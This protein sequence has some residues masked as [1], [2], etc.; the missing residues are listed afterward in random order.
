[1]AIIKGGYTMFINLLMNIWGC[2][3]MQNILR[4]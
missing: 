4:R 2:M 3:K 1:M